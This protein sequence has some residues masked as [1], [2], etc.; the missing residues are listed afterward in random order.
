[1]PILQSKIG[2]LMRRKNVAVLLE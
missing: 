2:K 1:M